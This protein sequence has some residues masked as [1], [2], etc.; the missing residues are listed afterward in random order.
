MNVARPLAF[1]HVHA[2]WDIFES[3]MYLKTPYRQRVIG[4]SENVALL[5]E[6]GVVV[7][8]FFRFFGS[9]PAFATARSFSTT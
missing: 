3:N 4:S 5:A 9:S 1:L 6:M 7:L 2:L 8:L